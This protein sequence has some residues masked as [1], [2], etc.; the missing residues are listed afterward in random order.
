[1]GVRAPEV[2]RVAVYMQVVVNGGNVFSR[3]RSAGHLNA[4]PWSSGKPLHWRFVL[5]PFL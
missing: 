3:L 4:A 2:A 5:S 1:M